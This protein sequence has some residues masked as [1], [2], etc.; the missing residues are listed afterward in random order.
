M[1]TRSLKHLVAITL[2][3]ALLLGLFSI[4]SA[5]E[6]TKLTI[7]VWGQT[8]T[9]ENGVKVI[10]ENNPEFASKVDIE[11]IT[12]GQGDPEVAEKY[13][14]SLASGVPCADIIQLNYTQLAEFAEA[15]AVVELTDVF[16]PV[17]DDML[18]A[19]KVLCTYNDKIVAS[20]GAINTKLYY[21][22]Q[23]IFDECGVD[24]TTWETVDDMI[25]GAKKIQETYPE[26]Y[27]YNM[28]H[29]AGAQD[30]GLY[31]FLM[32]FNARFTDENG[33]Y[34][35]N[36]DPGVRQAFETLKKL[37]DS[38]ICYDATDFNSGWEY[39]LAN[40][41]LIGQLTSNW[42]RYFVG[43]YAPEGAG[44]WTAC[45]WPTEIRQGSEAG[46]SIYVIP[47]FS[48]HPEEAK[49]FLRLFR[50]DTA[51]AQEQFWQS[52][53]VPTLSSAFEKITER[54]E[55]NYLVGN[56]GKSYWQIEYDCFNNGY[57]SIFPYTPKAAAEM[58][59]V[60]AYSTKY[61][62]GEMDLDSMLNDLNMDLEMQIGNPFE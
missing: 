49:E 28:S 4:A 30:Y 45:E 34:I 36:S 25:A 1:K 38:G 2:S 12:G 10:L 44:L 33:N 21:Y 13:R 57:Y 27:I 32:A 52:N 47:T 60:N 24:P 48:A 3:I 22:R 8:T 19:A 37:Y 11:V 59:I 41:E 31:T 54:A 40:G 9:M 61:F 58:S 39:G 51:M 6:K 14:L 7:M 5:E 53:A 55:H 20:P 35:L 29:M 56:H 46:G 62:T 15:N 17:W 26:C 23:D 42:F 50:A 43:V 16:S 18:D